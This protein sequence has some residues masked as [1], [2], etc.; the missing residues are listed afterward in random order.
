MLRLDSAP[1]SITL[2][3]EL[4]GGY[5]GFPDQLFLI[6]VGDDKYAANNVTLPDGQ[7]ING[8]ATFPSRDDASSYQ[9]ILAGLS[10]DI[11]AKSFE[12]ARQIAISKPIL[13]CVLL[14]H[15]NRVVDMC[16]VR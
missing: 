13:S 11:V 16:F 14:F 15:D 1:T 7:N 4:L 2:E 5:G 6:S 12:D 10:G 9:G 3:E 8:L